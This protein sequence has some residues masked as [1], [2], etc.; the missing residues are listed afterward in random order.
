MFVLAAMAGA[1]AVITVF[2][3][4]AFSGVFES[5]ASLPWQTKA[6]IA[7]SDFAVTFWPVMVVVAVL[8]YG[9]FKFWSLSHGE[10]SVGSD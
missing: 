10:N 1:I 5:C 3:I 6:L 9:T 7:T 8:S 4:P 2:V